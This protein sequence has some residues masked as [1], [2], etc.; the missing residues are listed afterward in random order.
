MEEKRKQLLA[1]SPQISILGSVR[2]THSLPASVWV[3][4]HN[5][6]HQQCHIHRPIISCSC[7]SITSGLQNLAWKFFSGQQHFLWACGQACH[8][9]SGREEVPP[10]MDLQECLCCQR[11]KNQEVCLP[12]CCS[13][14]IF[15]HELTKEIK[16]LNLWVESCISVLCCC[17][18]L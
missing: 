15:S 5:Y 17:Q 9:E 8:K 11:W 16:T 10:L 7:G 6:Y 18:L 14:P 13:P 4:Q 3:C 2:T 1:V 12:A